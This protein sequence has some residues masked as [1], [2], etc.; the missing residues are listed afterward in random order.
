AAA[1]DEAGHRDA[2]G[3]DLARGEAARLEHLEAVVSEGEL[4]TPVRLPLVASLL[5]LAELRSRWLKHRS[6]LLLHRGGRGL[7]GPGR[8]RAGGTRRRGALLGSCDDALGKHLA[9]E[10]PHL[11]ADLSVSGLRLGEA[12]VDV[13]A[14]RVQRNPAFAVPLVARHLGAAQPPRAGHADALGAELL[15]RLDGLLHRAPE[16]DAA[17]ELG[18]DVLGDEL[19]VDL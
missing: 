3:L 16:G 4:A 17:L 6:D 11:A 12:V 7:A 15:R 18:G 10:D 13:G 1:L 9:A 8:K 19:R 2:A 5:L 14:Q